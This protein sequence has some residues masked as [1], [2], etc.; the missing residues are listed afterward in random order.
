MGETIYNNT[1]CDTRFK[2]SSHASNDDPTVPRIPFLHS[3]KNWWCLPMET[4]LFYVTV[5]HLGLF[6]APVGVEVVL[7]FSLLYWISSWMTAAG[8]KKSMFDFDGWTPKNLL[9]HCFFLYFKITKKNIWRYHI[10]LKPCE[11]SRMMSQRQDIHTNKI[12]MK[13]KEHHMSAFFLKLG[14]IYL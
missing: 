2:I 6:S 11:V 8:W 5:L 13:R 1:G 3:M 4:L 14:N 10:S 9:C 7:S 12:Q